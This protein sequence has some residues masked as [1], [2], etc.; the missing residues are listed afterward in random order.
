M[1]GLS[2][3]AVAVG[4]GNQ[5]PSDSLMRGTQ[6]GRIKGSVANSVPE[7]MKVGGGTLDGLS[8][9]VLCEDV[10][11]LNLS[12][13]SQHLRPQVFSDTSPSGCGAEGLAGEAA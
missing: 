4:V 8:L 12:H 5:P 9:D 13:D 2:M 11:R 6:P 7:S 1:L 3:F 10:V